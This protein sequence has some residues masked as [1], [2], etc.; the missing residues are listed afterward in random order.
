MNTLRTTPALV[1]FSGSRWDGLEVQATR[2]PRFL[3]V[4]ESRDGVMLFPVEWQAPGCALART[5]YERQGTQ[6]PAE[7][8]AI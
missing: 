1:R 4:D 3:I 2:F 8:R 6:L 7:Y 5:I